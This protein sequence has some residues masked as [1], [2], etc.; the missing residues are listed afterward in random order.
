VTRIDETEFAGQVALVTG[1]GAGIGRGI[2]HRLAA[3]GAVVVPTDKH[4]G[5]LEAV[6]AELDATRPGAVGMARLLDIEHR[7]QFDQVFAEVEAELGPLAVYVWNA[8][9]NVPQPLFD[10]DPELFDRITYA[11]VNNCWYSCAAAAAQMRR[12][13]GGSIVSIGSI[14]P[15]V[16]ATV[17]EPAYAM[18]KAAVR[19]LILGLAHAGGPD[20]IRANEIVTGLVTGTRFTDSRPERADEVRRDVP[21]GRLASVEDIAEA[22]AFLCSDRA[23]FIS[24]EVLNVSGGLFVR[25]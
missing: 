6:A 7:E 1:A 3:G 23:G 5:R 8:A 19:A 17:R 11:N 9:L 24:G 2:C 16:V 14:A 12:R 21:L 15:D 20:N 10:H 22:V 18:S 4:T 13:G 25:L